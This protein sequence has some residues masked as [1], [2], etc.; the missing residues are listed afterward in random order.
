MKYINVLV[1]AS[2]IW[3][4]SCS[5][6]PTTRTLKRAEQLMLEAPDSAKQIL[7]AIP[8]HN[9]KSRAQKARFAL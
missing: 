3:L 6:A 9:L 1:L 4:F 8:R 2:C 7:N 5:H